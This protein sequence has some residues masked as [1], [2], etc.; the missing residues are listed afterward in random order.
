[1]PVDSLNRRAMNRNLS[2]SLTVKTD[3][4]LRPTYLSTYLLLTLPLCQQ[5][6]YTSDFVWSKRINVTWHSSILLA[7]GLSTAKDCNP[8]RRT[9]R[10]ERGGSLVA[11]SKRLP[12]VA[13]AHAGFT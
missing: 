2:C 7:F 11:T 8:C 6:I 12:G 13:P 3:C 9:A 1:M 5:L 4:G 10:H